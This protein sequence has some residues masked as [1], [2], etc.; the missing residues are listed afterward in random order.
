M[1]QDRAGFYSYT[2]LE[3]LF[4]ADMRNADLIVP[5]W[6]QLRTGDHVRLA[7]KETY[8]DV[9]L[10]PVSAVETGHYFV[11]RGWGAFVLVPLD[12]THTRFLVRSRQLRGPPRPS[13]VA[14]GVFGVLVY[15][16]AHFVME[17]GMV[18]G[19]KAR[20]ERGRRTR[21]AAQ[22]QARAASQTQAQT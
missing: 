5:E 10:V 1:G 18:L 7:S 22:T 12:A 13:D 16:P 21:T 8:G 9:P 15:D 3:N 17:R 14:W 19:V 20:A 6:Q 11:L 4:L 2:F